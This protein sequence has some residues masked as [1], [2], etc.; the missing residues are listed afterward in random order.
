MDGRPA[1]RAQGRVQ[2]G[3][4]STTSHALHPPQRSTRCSHQRA[5]AFLTILAGVEAVSIVGEAGAATLRVPQE[6]PTIAAAATVAV[7]GDSIL[8]G[9]GIYS[10]ESVFLRAGVVLFGSYEEQKPNL[11]FG[12]LFLLDDGPDST[13]VAGCIFVAEPYEFAIQAFT[14]RVRIDRCYLQGRGPWYW[15]AIYLMNGGAITRCEFINLLEGTGIRLRQ[16][17]MA[18]TNC[19][20]AGS[21]GIT[22]FNE[23]EL[24]PANVILRNNTLLSTWN[25][26]FLRPGS[27][28]EVVNNVFISA[29]L[30][31]CHGQ[32]P[33]T[34]VRYNDFWENAGSC[35]GYGAGNIFLD[36]MFCPTWPPPLPP[37]P[38]Y[39]QDDS[40]CVGAGEN[41]ANMGAYP[42]CSVALGV[43]TSE[44]PKPGF[45]HWVAPN[46][47]AAEADV[48][49]ASKPGSEPRVAI[50]DVAGRLVEEIRGGWQTNG[51]LVRLRW[52]AAGMPPGVYFYRVELG[53]EVGTGRMLKAK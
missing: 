34:S 33:P 12:T 50:Y 32:V 20:I 51:G 7:S 35:F 25:D 14:S 27:T 41:G 9:P 21:I 53:D 36:P 43:E 26:F 52:L 5:V 24:L 37:G 18:V 30:A 10:N 3:S 48:F 38:F 16:G 15:S 8:V 40:P 39:L 19:V 45:V 29:G 13:W 31:T 28:M 17:T 1:S 49:V 42:L 2:A 6:Y 4:C 47:F 11:Q 23:Y 22:V 44:A 46:P